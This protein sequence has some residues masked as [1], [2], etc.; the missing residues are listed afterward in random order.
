MLVLTTFYSNIHS[1]SEVNENYEL[2]F[3][4]SVILFLVANL[5]SA[6]I[7]HHR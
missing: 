5:F 7:A 2:L 3:P 6:L 1:D 4:L